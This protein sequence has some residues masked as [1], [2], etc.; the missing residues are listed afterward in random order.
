MT[1]TPTPPPGR[2]EILQCRDGHRRTHTDTAGDAHRIAVEWTGP[3][4]RQVTITATSPTNP[5]RWAVRHYTCHPTN[6]LT[7][8]AWLTWHNGHYLGPNP[9]TPFPSVQQSCSIDPER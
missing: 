3:G 4:A 9:D 5:H 2:F 7:V 1:T 8:T 6:G